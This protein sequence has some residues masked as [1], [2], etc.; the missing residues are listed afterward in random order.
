MRKLAFLAI[1]AIGIAAPGSAS[2]VEFR[3]LDGSNNNLNHREWGQVGTQYARVAPAN[4]ADGVST[5]VYASNANRSPRYISNRIFNDTF[6]TLFSEGQISQFGWLWGQFVDHTLDLRNENPGEQSNIPFKRSDPLE[7]FVNGTA[8]MD[9][10]RTPAAP[11]TGAGSGNPRQQ[12]NTVNSFIDAFDVYGGTAD[13]VEWLRTGPVDGNLANNGPGL[14]LP[15]GYLPRADA[16]GN[17]STAPAMDLMGPLNGMPQNAIV[18]GDVRANENIGLTSLQTLF[19]REHNRIVALLPTSLSA[20]M[21]FD[22]ARRVVGAEQQYI[23]YNEFLPAFGVELPPYAGYDPTVDPTIANEFASVG[24]R[25]HSSVNGELQAIAPHG[26]WSNAQLQSFEDRGIEE[27]TLPNGDVELTISMTL[28]FGNPS[29]LTQVGEGPL[30]KG[31]AANVEYSNDEQIDNKFRSILFQLPEPGTDPATCVGDTPAPGCFAAV[32]DLGAIDVQ[33][34]RD[35]GMPTYNQMRIAYGLPPARSYTDIT[36]EWTADLP[37][38]ANPLDP[39]ND[40]VILTFDAFRNRD[41]TYVTPGEGVFPTAGERHSTM[42]SRLKG[43]YGAGNVNKVD[44][45]VGMVCEPHVDGKDLGELQLA[46]WTK[47][48]EALRDGDRFFYLNDAYLTTIRRTWGVDYRQT[49]AEVIARNTDSTTQPF[50]FSVE[51]V[52]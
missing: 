14:M 43:L 31:M 33:R 1:L 35:H 40:P 12:I 6:V 37:P 10:F 18:A 38:D 3:S 34:A 9:F 21:R 15:G 24:F 27:A 42:A 13:R 8:S 5:M 47:Q 29:L 39:L 19:A 11:G 49:L 16:R 26:Y 52:G 48:F 2:A 22:I 36:D 44:A 51:G 30:L 41:G 20:Q 25:G 46:I 23:T 45:F 17:V 50:S 32:Q 28:A 7:S 4:Y